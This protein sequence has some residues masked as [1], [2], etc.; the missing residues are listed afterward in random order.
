MIFDKC[1]SRCSKTQRIIV[2]EE[3]NRKHCATN[4]SRD[5]VFHFKIDGDII[6]SGSSDRRCDYA[7]EDETK[8]TLYLIE[9][10]GNDVVHAVEQIEG[11]IIKFA[12][13]FSGYKL[14]P[15]VVCRKSSTHSIYSSKVVRF[16]RRYPK[17]IIKENVIEESI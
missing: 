16:I 11:T 9:L 7:L 17:T 5:K 8:K 6:P 15:R 2:S 1:F 4:V 14:F 10:K 3:N 12:D 13:S